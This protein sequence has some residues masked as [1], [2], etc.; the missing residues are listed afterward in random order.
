ME[1][2][3]VRFITFH[4]DTAVDNPSIWWQN[5]IVLIFLPKIQKNPAPSHGFN[6][7]EKGKNDATGTY[8]SYD[9]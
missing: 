4:R 9:R 7:L 8:H 6:F 1:M 2:R 3:I 5:I